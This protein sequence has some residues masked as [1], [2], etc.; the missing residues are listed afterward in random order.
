MNYVVGVEEMK[1]LGN[2][3]QLWRSKYGIEPNR[4]GTYKI[5][6]VR[7]WVLLDVFR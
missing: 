2:T 4:R 5:K 1:T 7:A 6:S 3:E